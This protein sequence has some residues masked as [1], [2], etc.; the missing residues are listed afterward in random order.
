MNHIRGFIKF[1]SIGILLAL[2]FFTVGIKTISN[3]GLN[4]DEPA[5][6]TRGQA[7]LQLLLTGQK[8]YSDGDL[9]GKRSSSYKIQTYNASY[10]LKNDSGHPSLNGILAAA[11]NRI[12]HEELGIL[13]DLEAYHLFGIFVSS[14]LIFLIYAMVRRRYGIF[15][16]I[17]S[18][19]SLA[20][21]PLFLGESHFNIK[22]PVET[23][24]YAFTI[25][26]FYLTLETKKVRYFLLSSLFFG[27]AFSTK[28][29]ILFLP[30][31]LVPYLIIR[32][33]NVVLRA[34][35]KVIKHIPIKLYLAF[36]VGLVLV[37]AIHYIS[38]PYLWSDPINR[39]FEIIRY[40]Q[41][42]GTGSVHQ[43]QYLAGGWNMYPPFFITISTPLYVFLLFLIGFIF[44]LFKLRGEKDKFF[45]LL[46]LWMIVPIFRVML[47]G[48]SIYSGVRQIMEYV[49]PL[50]AICGI[51]AMGIRDVLSKTFR[52]PFIISLF[53][54]LGFLPLA[55]T[56]YRMHPNEN[57]FINSL[58]GGL[59][60]AVEKQI[61]GAGE[62]MGN[63]YLQGLKWL[64]GNAPE[65]AKY[66]TPV[67][68]GSNVPRQFER[69][70]L[71]FGGF[72]S[73]ERREGE[74]M[75]EMIS[76]DFPPPRYNF[77]YLDTFLNPVYVLKVDGATILKVWKN[78]KEHTKK[79]YLNE[80]EEKISRV[81]GGI[82]EEFI[83]VEL[84]NLASITRIEIDHDNQNCIDQG[85]GSIVYFNEKNEQ[86]GT[87]DDLYLSQGRYAA[88]LQTRNHFVYFFPATKT[89]LLRLIPADTNLCLLQ[90]RSI[91][92]YGLADLK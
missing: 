36:P 31:S 17:V 46:I 73:G 50:A 83:Q 53:I 57:V 70:D 1:Y 51:G 6:F 2:V 12:F 39:F 33:W 21:Y 71:K 19:L 20:L 85:S 14:S 38:R 44:G 7:Y 49:F 64:N 56:L 86:L 8:K 24:F 65:G 66:G 25:Y 3:Y 76:V 92:V 22:D 34:K 41:D 61:P 40:Y 48:A 42:I 54:I 4:I 87:A 27:F 5:H 84:G 10:Y 29:N 15:A 90:Y 18:A 37:L 67:G 77:K 62:S 45:F 63:V 13:G 58:V 52:K 32:Y 82:A 89:K 11:T 81:R 9:S 78:D 69:S 74:Y 91:K 28:F 80:K 60:G 16:G 26:F 72:F 88:S 59:G 47:P 23:T 79:G 55:M 75:M 35:L 43:I 68:L 30:F